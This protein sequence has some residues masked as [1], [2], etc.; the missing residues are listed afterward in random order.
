[1]LGLKLSPWTGQ[2]GPTSSVDRVQHKRKELNFWHW[3]RHF[4]GGKENV[5]TVYMDN[6]CEFAVTH[7]HGPLSTKMTPYS[8]LKW[9]T[10][11]RR[12]HN[13]ARCGIS[14]SWL[15]CLDSKC[16]STQTSHK[17]KAHGQKGRCHIGGKWMVILAEWEKAVVHQT[18]PGHLSRDISSCWVIQAQILYPSMRQSCQKTLYPELVHASTPNEED[19]PWKEFVWKKISREQ[20][21]ILWKSGD[22]LNGD[23]LK[24]HK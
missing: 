17:N 21:D 7:V 4:I 6:W 12:N 14:R 16:S 3:H 9:N 18:S 11:Q 19:E 24:G 15:P 13:P 1:M 20:G 10:K 2:C 22:Y 5:I 8:V 23:S